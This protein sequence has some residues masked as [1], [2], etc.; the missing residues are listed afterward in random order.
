MPNRLRLDVSGATEGRR[1][2]A[3]ATV[4]AKGTR[5]SAALLDVRGQGLNASARILGFR[6]AAV[7][8]ETSQL[9]A[10]LSHGSP[11]AIMS[12]TTLR[13][14]LTD[15]EARLIG[16]LLES[17][18]VASDDVLALGVDDP[19]LWSFDRGEPTGYLG[20]CDPARLAEATGLNV[21]DAFPARDVAGGGQGGP[22]TALPTWILLR[23]PLRHRVLLDLGRT[24]RLM[25]LP[26]GRLENAD[27]EV[28]AFEVGPGTSLLDVL[29]Q[30]LTGG[31]QTFDP[32]GRLAVQGK[33]IAELVGHWIADPYFECPP[34]RWH[35][36]G[37]RPERFLADAVQ[38]AVASDWSVRDLLC[39]AT[40]FIAEVV[41]RAVLR[42]PSVSMV[43]EILV[44][45][46]GQH[47]GLLLHE[48]GR[49][50][51][52]P[53]LHLEE[54]HMPDDG[55]EAAAVALLAMMHLDRVPANPTSITKAAT[56]RLLGRLTSGTAKNWQLLLDA[57]GVPA[58]R[59][60]RAAV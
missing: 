39:T 25:Y 38:M 40:H 47:N 4:A 9:F 56:P 46:G 22:L 14:Q 52:L 26:A 59:P 28:V 2:I 20:L 43:D 11:T 45:G 44:T 1:W 3:G 53:L 24:V 8:R 21:V 15:L 16:E 12:L 7:P 6:T 42:L 27:T 51:N 23:D 55:W 57:C 17:L 32:G 13:S 58:T 60:L 54:L 31:Q 29:T 35:P 33:R 37:V 19:G 49:R 48:I 5:V 34:P 36:R 18:G 30:K 50:T 41:S 10:A